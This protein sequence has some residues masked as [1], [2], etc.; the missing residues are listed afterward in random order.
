MDND[1]EI[2]ATRAEL[3]E[4]FR[5]WDTQARAGDWP[6]EQ[7]FEASADHLITLIHTAQA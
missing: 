5:T 1:T 2:T 4:A 3:V 7:D 6:N